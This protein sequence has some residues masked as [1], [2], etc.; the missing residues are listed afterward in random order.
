MKNSPSSACAL[1]KVS[2]PTTKST[3]SSTQTTYPRPILLDLT[4]L[5]L[6]V[7][8]NSNPR[9]VEEY[10][11]L[12][13]KLLDGC[14]KIDK[15]PWPKDIPI[16]IEDVKWCFC[17]TGEPFF[18]VIQTPAHQQRRMQCARGVM[19]MFQPKWIF[20]IL[21]SSDSKRASA[22]SK[23]RALLAKHGFNNR[24]VKANLLDKGKNRS[25]FP[26]NHHHQYFSSGST[27]NTTTYNDESMDDSSKELNKKGGGRFSGVGA[28]LKAITTHA[29]HTASTV[30][31]QATE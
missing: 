17:F 4:P 27:T 28:K 25:F 23:V 15:K 3:S 10:R 2:K 5:V 18:T 30:D 7:K 29:G 11:S 14:A 6:L 31:V 16:T 20:D 21:F 9:T 12:F 26:M 1:P 22:L 8:Q 13:W 19:I 24:S